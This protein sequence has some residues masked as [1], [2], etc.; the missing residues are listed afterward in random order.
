[1]TGGDFEANV[2]QLAREN[3]LMKEYGISGAA[4]SA[5]AENKTEKEH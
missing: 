3:D 2:A 4:P 1:M 5:P